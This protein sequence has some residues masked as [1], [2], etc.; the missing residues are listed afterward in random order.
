VKLLKLNLICVINCTTNKKP[1]KIQTLDFFLILNFKQRV[2]L[3]RRQLGSYWLELAILTLIAFIALRALRWLETP[4]NALVVVVAM[5][6]PYRVTGVGPR[7]GTTQPLAHG[8][9]IHAPRRQHS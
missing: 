3:E 5:Q 9:R 8:R 7:V 2:Q 6:V 4:L 1:T